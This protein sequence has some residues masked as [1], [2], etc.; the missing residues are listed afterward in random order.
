MWGE[1]DN[2]CWPVRALPP[3][4]VW[5]CGRCL[6]WA[7]N[8]RPF[9]PRARHK[10]QVAIWCCHNP[11][12]CHSEAPQ[13]STV[14]PDISDKINFSA[15]SCIAKRASANCDRTRGGGAETAGAA[16]PTSSTKSSGRTPSAN[17]AAATRARK[18]LLRSITRC[19]RSP[20]L[21]VTLPLASSLLI[22]PPFPPILFLSSLNGSG[23]LRCGSCSCDTAR[24]C[25]RIACQSRR[26]LPTT[27]GWRED[28]APNYHAWL[29]RP[30]H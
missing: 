25:G 20:T 15:P 6:M 21:C 26:A 1:V 8:P 5:A 23:N 9:W 28:D 22:F 17:Q 19:L 12:C 11:S 14:R 10:G 2:T 13:P 30:I 7:A 27:R 18:E 16:T 24:S 3:C 4:G 29:P